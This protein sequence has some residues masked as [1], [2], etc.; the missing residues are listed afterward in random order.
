[1]CSDLR[2]KFLL[3]RKKSAGI[4]GVFQTFLTKIS[5]D[6]CREDGCGDLFRDSIVVHPE[7]H[8]QDDY[9]KA[10]SI[11]AKLRNRECSMLNN[12]LETLWLFSGRDI[13]VSVSGKNPFE[14][15]ADRICLFDFEDNY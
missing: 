2:Q 4:L 6:L 1:M 3:A 12:K 13:F 10:Y 5:G 15:K 11:C 14:I 7:N 9:S 8:S